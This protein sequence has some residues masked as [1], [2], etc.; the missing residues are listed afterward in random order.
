M[1]H[2]KQYIIY[3]HVEKIYTVV[4]EINLLNIQVKL[5]DSFSKFTFL[6][7]KFR[8][9]SKLISNLSLYWTFRQLVCLLSFL[10][11]FNDK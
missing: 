10:S 5:T 6:T 11:Y 9:F 1:M 3:G 8:N 2:F 7:L 4:R